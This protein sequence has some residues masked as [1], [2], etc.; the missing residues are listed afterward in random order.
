[1]DAN[2]NHGEDAE[3]AKEAIV[4]HEEDTDHVD[5]WSNP[6]GASLT[7]PEQEQVPVAPVDPPAPLQRISLPPIVLRRELKTQED[8]ITAHHDTDTAVALLEQQVHRMTH[9]VIKSNEVSNSRIETLSAVN[10]ALTQAVVKLSVTQQSQDVRLESQEV[11]LAA[12]EADRKPS[13]RKLVESTGNAQPKRRPQDEVGPAAPEPPAGQAAGQAAGPAVIASG[14]LEILYQLFVRPSNDVSNLLVIFR[15]L[16]NYLVIRTDR[17]FQELLSR[18][19]THL[20]GAR[21]TA[22]RPWKPIKEMNRCVCLFAVF[23]SPYIWCLQVCI[24]VQRDSR[25]YR[26]RPLRAVSVLVEPVQSLRRRRQPQRPLERKQ[27]LLQQPE[28]HPLLR[29]TARRRRA[30]SPSCSIQELPQERPSADEAVYGPTTCNPA[31]VSTSTLELAQAGETQARLRHRTRRGRKLP[32]NSYP[33]LCTS[34]SPSRPNR[35]PS[36]NH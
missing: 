35:S 7:F 19:L 2:A 23:L 10:A 11:R 5:D 16:P 26:S 12:L 20:T 9:A 14:L 6:F 3:E 25:V 22:S 15:V 27:V 30:S 33:L 8:I 1:M 28:R 36:R 32:I 21:I 17:K 4:N 24:F 13:K 34:R 18:I 31:G 29:P